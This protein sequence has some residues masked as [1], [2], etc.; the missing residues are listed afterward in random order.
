MFRAII[1][2]SSGALGCVASSN[3]PH[4]DHL[5]RSPHPGYWPATTW[6]RYTSNCRTQPNAQEDGQ[7]IARNMLSWLKLLITLS[8][9]HLVGYWYYLYQGCMVKQISN[10]IY[11]FFTNNISGYTF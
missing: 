8:L 4:T 7:I 5:S 1:C 9:L 10:L 6:V 11:L 2:P 3:I